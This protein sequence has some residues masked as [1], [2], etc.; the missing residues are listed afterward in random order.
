MNGLMLVIYLVY[1][2]LAL[3]G[4]TLARSQGVAVGLAFVS[5]IIISGIAAIPTI[6][7]YLPGRLF[8]WGASLV[9]GGS[10]SAWPALWISLGIV[11]AALIT[12][13]LVFR[14]QE[15]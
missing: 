11:A 7:D 9:M 8:A 12:A 2:A 14:R 6:G 4:S 10:I 3:L 5:L 13:C 1:M 15:V